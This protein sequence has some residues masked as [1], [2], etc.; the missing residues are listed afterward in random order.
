MDRFGIDVIL[1]TEKRVAT[2]AKMCEKG[3][4]DRMVLSHDAS[5][6]IDWY[7]PA[8]VKALIPKWNYLHILDD[9]I[10]ALRQTGVGEQQLRAM[11]IDNPRRFFETQGA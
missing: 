5:C 8:A 1:P 2:I 4:A 7:E 9:V 6:Y 3:Y 10:P 11:T